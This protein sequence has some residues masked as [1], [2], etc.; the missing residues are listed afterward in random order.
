MPRLNFFGAQNEVAVVASCEAALDLEEIGK[1]WNAG[2][3][4]NIGNR[5]ARPLRLDREFLG[6]N[7]LCDFRCGKTATESKFH[8][9]GFGRRCVVEPDDSRRHKRVRK[10]HVVRIEAV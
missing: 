4:A 3:G 9:V 8:D 6:G 7:Y 5:K 1:G 10:L 2:A